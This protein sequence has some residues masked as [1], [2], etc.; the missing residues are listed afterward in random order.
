MSDFEYT[1]IEQQIQKLKKQHLIINN[2]K[3]AIQALRT[4]GYYNIINGYRDPYITRTYNEKIY[5]PDVSFEQIYSLFILDRKLRNAVMFSM[6]DLEE[7]LRAVVA[8]IIGESFGTK[9]D[10]YLSKTNYRDRHVRNIK[11]TR[12]N[13]LKSLTDIA[14]SSYK[15]PVRYYREK[16]HIVP[17]WILLKAT[18]FGTL[19]N[20]IKI[21]LR[22]QRE[23]LV[24]ALYDT[25]SLQLNMDELKDLLSDTLSMCLEYR[26]LAAHGGRIYNYV[27]HSLIRNFNTSTTHGGLGILLKCLRF[28]SYSIPFSS[29]NN[30]IISALSSYCTEYPNDISRI[31]NALGCKLEM[32]TLAYVNIKT[33]IFHSDPHCSGSTNLSKVFL[34]DAIAGNFVP[35]KRCVTKDY[36]S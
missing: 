17:P 3:K 22:P 29:L 6:T 8:E 31:E 4:Y 14:E 23:S 27:P 32:H 26:N 15:E 9:H 18:D 12:E 7:H 21:F 5:S 16:H 2:E 24:S 36:Y 10:L 35:C 19:I 28:F 1:T 34:D 13:I 30:A 25:D 11:F 20:Y 33:K